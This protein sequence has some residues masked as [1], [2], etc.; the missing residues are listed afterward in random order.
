[1]VD[2]GGPV[3]AAALTAGPALVKPNVAE[4][5]LVLNSPAGADRDPS[6]GEGVEAVDAGEVAA[7]LE[8]VPD[9][10][11]AEVRP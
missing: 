9:M 3:L 1:M 4:A 8:G 7:V 11:S 5:E 2:V 10:T 6:V